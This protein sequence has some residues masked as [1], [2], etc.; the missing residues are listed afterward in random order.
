M[1]EKLE[2]M[3]SR[4]SVI[5]GPYVKGDTGQGRRVF[6]EALS[7][8]VEPPNVSDWSQIR[9]LYQEE[10]DN[11]WIGRKSAAQGCRDA[12]RRINEYRAAHK[13]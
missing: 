4:L 9:P 13:P 11:I 8:A 1:A 7:Y 10:L 5:N 3:P 12:A 2:K 6:A